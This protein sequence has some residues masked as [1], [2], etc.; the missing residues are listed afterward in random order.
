MAWNLDAP[1]T[2]LDWHDQRQTLKT[3]HQVHI[4]KFWNSQIETKQTLT[5]FGTRTNTK[6][7]FTHYGTL[8]PDDSELDSQFQWESNAMMRHIIPGIHTWHDIET[9]QEPTL[10]DTP[11]EPSHIFGKQTDINQTNLHTRRDTNKCQTK[12]TNSHFGTLT[13]TN[14]KQTFPHFGTITGTTTQQ[15]LIHFGTQITNPP[16]LRNTHTNNKQTFPHF[17][18]LTTPILK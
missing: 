11:N 16:T 15:I 13:N 4:H 3:T 18:T 2:Y 9:H 10:T 8:T 17:A 7:T 6:Q 1:G 14:N 12:Q 5:H